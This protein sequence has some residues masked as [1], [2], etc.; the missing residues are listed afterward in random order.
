MPTPARRLSA[1]WAPSVWLASLNFVASWLPFPDATVCVVPAGAAAF[2]TG[3]APPAGAAVSVA[4]G[5]AAGSPV[6]AAVAVAAGLVVA[7]PPELEACVDEPPA[8][9]ALEPLVEEEPEVVLD[10]ED[11]PGLVVVVVLVPVLVDVVR[12]ELVDRP[13]E[14]DLLPERVVVVLEPVVLPPVLAAAGC[15]AVDGLVAAGC[16][17]AD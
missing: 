3:A 12:P 6:A 15:V 8:E 17:G 14:L 2:A 13:P 9:D 1:G 10:D 16:E 11:E 5:A 4:T 7:V